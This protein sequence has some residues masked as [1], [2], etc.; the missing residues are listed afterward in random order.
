MKDCKIYTKSG[1]QIF[2]VIWRLAVSRHSN[3]SVGDEDNV[4]HIKETN[5]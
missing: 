4:S 3:V 5:V 2:S 1:G